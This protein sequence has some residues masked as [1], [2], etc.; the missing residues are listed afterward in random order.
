MWESQPLATIRACTACTGIT[1]PFTQSFKV[2]DDPTVEFVRSQKGY[3]TFQIALEYHV[4]N[5]LKTCSIKL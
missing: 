1:L 2:M 3:K 4:W 5:G